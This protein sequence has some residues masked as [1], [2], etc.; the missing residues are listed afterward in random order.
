MPKPSGADCLRALVLGAAGYSIYYFLLAAGVKGAGVSFSVGII[1]LLPLTILAVSTPPK[2]W[3]GLAWSALL[4]LSGV[5]MIAWDLFSLEEFS[6][7][8]ETR[9]RGS[10]ACFG[11]LLLWTYFAVANA[12][13]LRSN[14]AW[15]ALDWAGV[16]GVASAIISSALFLGT[17]GSGAGE[18]FLHGVRD[19]RLLLWTAFMGVVGA[20]G[21]TALWNFASRHLP[22]SWLGPLLVFES[23]FGLWFGFLY[24]RRGPRPLEGIALVAL[25][26]G[27]VLGLLALSREDI[28]H[29]EK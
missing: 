29:E 27:V 10:I 11:A 19:P 22:G 16:V 23:I 15:R 26:G 5:G 9:L 2:R 1:G 24:D 18:R 7:A 21:A 28:R 12:K 8:P 17:E 20:W 3:A 14:P 6:L 13:F 25:L 4:I